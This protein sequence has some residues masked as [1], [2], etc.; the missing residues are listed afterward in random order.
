MQL[1]DVKF[2]AF[3]HAAPEDGAA[4]LMHF[5]HVLFRFFPGITKDA[6]KDHCD[7]GHQIDGIVVHDNQPG[8]INVLFRLRFLLNRRFLDG[9]A[10]GTPR[11]G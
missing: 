6:L 7:I 3:P 5:E 10:N 1:L 11:N 8:K 4:L 2:G 9:G